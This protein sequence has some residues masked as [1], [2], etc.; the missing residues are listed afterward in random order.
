MASILNRQ[1]MIAM[2]QLQERNNAKLKIAASRPP[3]VPAGPLQKIPESGI[4]TLRRQS[5]TARK[6][7]QRNKKTTKNRIRN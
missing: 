6:K 3:R 4:A 5:G 1:R 7:K 2:Q